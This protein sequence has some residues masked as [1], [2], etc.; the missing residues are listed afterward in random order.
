MNTTP[1]SEAGFVKTPAIA[2][3][4][5]QSTKTIGDWVRRRIIPCYSPTP[6]TRLFKVAEVDA[7]LS[8]YRTGGV[9]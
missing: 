9:A 2:R 6:R 3:H 8:N 4:L 1:P 7:A 5:S